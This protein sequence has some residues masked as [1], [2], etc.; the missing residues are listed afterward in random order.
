MKSYFMIFKFSIMA[1][2]FFKNIPI[3]SPL[4]P[5]EFTNLQLEN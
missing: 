1:F 2:S 3:E 5:K 4:A